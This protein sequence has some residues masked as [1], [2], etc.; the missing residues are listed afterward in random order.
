MSLF[1]PALPA[2]CKKWRSTFPTPF[3][4]NHVILGNSNENDGKT[5]ITF[6]YFLVLPKS[7]LQDRTAVKL[8][9]R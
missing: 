5:I 6:R 4:L 3:S 1:S 8:E 9:I 7:S 2:R